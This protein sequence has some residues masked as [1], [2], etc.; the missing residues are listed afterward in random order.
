MRSTVNRRLGL[1]LQEMVMNRPAKYPVTPLEGAHWQGIH[2][3]LHVMLDDCKALC[4][5]KGQ[6][7]SPLSTTRSS[8][9]IS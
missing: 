6:R 8:A 3:L 7:D 9:D 2:V 5:Y 4:S 1:I